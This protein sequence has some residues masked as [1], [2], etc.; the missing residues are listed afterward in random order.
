MVLTSA[1]S[2]EWVRSN[3]YLIVKHIGAEEAPQFGVDLD[4]VALEALQFFDPETIIF[5]VE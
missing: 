4:D 3:F 2:S 1:G 5:F